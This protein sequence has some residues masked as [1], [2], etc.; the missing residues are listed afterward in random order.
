M[1]AIVID[2][3]GTGILK[4]PPTHSSYQVSI[5]V[6]LR[7]CPMFQ[8]MFSSSNIIYIGKRDD[9]LAI[10]IVLEILHSLPARIP[11]D[12]LTPR[13]LAKIAD[14]VS[15]WGCLEHLGDYPEAWIAEVRPKDGEEFE[16]YEAW[17]RIASG[18]RRMD[19]QKFIVEKHAKQWLRQFG[20]PQ[21]EKLKYLIDEEI[22]GTPRKFL[23]TF[24][25][26]PLFVGY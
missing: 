16:P 2:P 14:V 15:K 6:M 7:T 26:F 24:S 9:P 20:L 12:S 11:K 25:P 4:L 1:E 18:F 8:T 19:I 22:Y 5:E 13:I 17:L 10:G 3:A 21:L 23:P